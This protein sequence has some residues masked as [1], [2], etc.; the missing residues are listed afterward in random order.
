[1][2]AFF[3]PPPFMRSQVTA[4]PVVSSFNTA[5]NTTSIN[6]GS[7]GILSNLPIGTATTDRLVVVVVHGIFAIGACR[8][9]NA[10]GASFT[11]VHETTTTNCF[12]RVFSMVIPTGTTATIAI[13]NG[14]SAATIF[15][16]AVYSVS[17]YTSSTPTL[18]TATPTATD[19]SKSL[20]IAV[21][22]GGLCLATQTT[23]GNPAGD[24]GGTLSVVQ[25]YSQTLG[26]TPYHCRSV[27]F[28]AV[29]GASGNVTTTRSRVLSA[30]VWR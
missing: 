2:V 11:L 9:N 22:S 8:L 24:F 14:H 1:M 13:Q 18:F 30:C 25:D 28:T 5:A 29:G 7:Y 3:C 16:V 6:S 27:R 26:G 10:A 4:A 19:A 17:G 20:D 15:S 23:A 21:P 12:Q